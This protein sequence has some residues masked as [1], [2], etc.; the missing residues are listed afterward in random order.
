MAKQNEARYPGATPDIDMSDLH[1]L[2]FVGA[3]MLWTTSALRSLP[4]VCLTNIVTTNS[5][6]DVILFMLRTNNVLIF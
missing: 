1:L 5:T 6:R 3:T 2:P 4:S